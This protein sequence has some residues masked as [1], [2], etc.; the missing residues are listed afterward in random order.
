MNVP[1]WC[2]WFKTIDMH[3]KRCNWF[4]HFSLTGNLILTHLLPPGTTHHQFKNHPIKVLAGMNLGSQ[5]QHYL[6]Y[7][8]FS[9]QCAY[10]MEFSSFTPLSLTSQH[11]CNYPDCPCLEGQWVHLWQITWGQLQMSRYHCKRQERS[12]KG[13]EYWLVWG[14]DQVLPL[15][16]T[17]TDHHFKGY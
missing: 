6:A 5:F 17:Y 4:I 14:E 8:L 3:K 2:L 12:W 13:W 1:I 10:L 7:I 16:C 15:I 11:V 9:H